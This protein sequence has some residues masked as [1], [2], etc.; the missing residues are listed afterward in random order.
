VQPDETREPKE[1]GKSDN[2]GA[3]ALRE[4]YPGDGGIAA[5]ARD[6]EAAPSVVCRWYWGDRKPN[7]EMRARIQDRLHIDWRLFDAGI[8]GESSSEPAA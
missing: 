5:A 2:E 3:R 7:S 6:L 8:A 4:K 1:P